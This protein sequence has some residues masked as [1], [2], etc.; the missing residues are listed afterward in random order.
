MFVFEFERHLDI[1]H[2]LSCDNDDIKIFQKVK[3][4]L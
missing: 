3:K 2:C 4:K 1:L